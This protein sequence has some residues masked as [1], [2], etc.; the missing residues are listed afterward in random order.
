MPVCHV[1]ESPASS[2]EVKNTW[3]YT[4]APPYAFMA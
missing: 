4:S 2:A 1:D 3:S